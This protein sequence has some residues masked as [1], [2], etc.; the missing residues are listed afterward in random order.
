MNSHNPNFVT[1]RA[2]T[3]NHQNISISEKVCF[4]ASDYLHAEKNSAFAQQNGGL[5]N[6]KKDF[7][8]FVEQWRAT[9]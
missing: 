7:V 3:L 8:A 5:E 6:L 2:I 4:A 9:L 1:A